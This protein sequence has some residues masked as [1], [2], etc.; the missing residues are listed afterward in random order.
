[1]LTAW[2]ALTPPQSARLGPSTLDLL[3]ALHPRRVQHPPQLV[4]LAPQAPSAHIVVWQ[5]QA[6]SAK[7]A[8]I[9]LLALQP[10]HSTSALQALAAQ[11][12]QMHTDRASRGLISLM[13]FRA[14]ASTVQLAATAL[15]HERLQPSSALLAITAV[16]TQL[17]RCSLTVR[18]PT[19][20]PL[21][22]SQPLLGFRRQQSAN[23]VPMASTVRL[24]RW[25][26]TPQ[27]VPLATTVTTRKIS[28]TRR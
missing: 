17:S 24:Q 27:P 13:S 4:R 22:M 8:T 1:M 23:V 7:L 3:L 20:V 28:T 25:P 19:L 18:G 5:L 15:R 16:Q 10:R 2:L 9:V 11:Q 21:A 6:C 14:A 26:A 12:A